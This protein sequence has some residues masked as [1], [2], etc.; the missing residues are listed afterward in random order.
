MLWLHYKLST[1]QLTVIHPQ[2]GGLERSPRVG[3][4]HHQ[5]SRFS[6]NL[7]AAHFLSQTKN[8]NNTPGPEQGEAFSQNNKSTSMKWNDFCQNYF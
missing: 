6:A 5:I 7:P 1:F 4:A 3:P 8:Y 2:P